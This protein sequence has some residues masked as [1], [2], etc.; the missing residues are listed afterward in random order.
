M[1]LKELKIDTWVG[2]PT[3]CY[4]I[5]DEDGKTVYASNRTINEKVF[6][7]DMELIGDYHSGHFFDVFE[8][9]APDGSIQYL[10][11]LSS[12]W[13]DGPVPKALDYCVLDEDYHILEGT[14]FADRDSLSAR[15]FEL[16]SGIS[17]NN[18]I[19][20]KYVYQNA[21]GEKRTLA[22]LSFNLSGKK[23]D[24][25]IRSA[26]SLWMIGVPTVLLSIILFVILFS[27][28]VKRCIAPLNQTIVSYQKGKENEINPMAV[29]SEF[30]DTVSNFKGLVTQLEKTR[31]EKEA[32][33]EEKQKL[34]VDISHD[35]KTPL[36]VIQGYAEALSQG[37]VPPEKQERYLQTIFS[38]SRLATEL[39]NDLF[40]FTQMEHPDYPLHL[41][42]MDFTE[43][44]KG[45]F[46][47]KY[48]EITDAGFDV[49]YGYLYFSAVIHNNNAEN[50]IL[51]PTVRVT[52]RD[53]QGNL[54]GTEDQVLNLIYPGQDCQWAGM[55]YF[56]VAEEPSVVEFEA[57][58]PDE[59]SIVAPAALEHAEYSPLEIEGVGK[60]G[61]RFLGEVYNANDYDID[62]VAVVVMFRD[63]AGSLLAGDATFI[64]SVRAGRKTPF[65]MD[66]SEDLVTENYEVF[67]IPWSLY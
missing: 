14:L 43:F 20:E 48:T 28:R 15:E 1:I 54:M 2:D 51:F 24:E 29:P 4:I 58:P 60:N 45:F 46:A 16:L 59:Y 50:A 36:T 3:N 11:Y 35:L 40:F 56:E 49:S 39:V 52:A 67:A 7:Q 37:R 6:Y 13:H 32:L 5:F 44:V 57:L 33:Y 34:I 38:K 65:D 18:G 62:Q 47:E 26:N 12:Y 10:V 27:R 19:L 9:L 66:I 55:A 25:I 22:F 23:Y 64:D 21:A 53:A 61:T 30:Y 42:P 8:D 63:D 17:R 41:E 31:E